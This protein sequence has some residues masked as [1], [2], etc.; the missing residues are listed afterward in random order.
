MSAQ[1]ASLWQK[2]IS[3]KIMLFV[4]LEREIGNKDIVKVIE[5]VQGIVPKAT[6]GKPI[7]SLTQGIPSTLMS[8][9]GGNSIRLTNF[10]YSDKVRGALFMEFND[11]Q[12]INNNLS[13]LEKQAEVMEIPVYMREIDINL[14]LNGQLR[15][16]DTPINSLKTI[17][18]PRYYSVIISGECPRSGNIREK[19]WREIQVGINPEEA[20]QI[21]INGVLR[22]VQI[23][24]EIEQFL[25]D[26]ETIYEKL[27]EHT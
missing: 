17:N 12:Q 13:I 20:S 24:G 11:R 10:V 3:S 21:I 1:T 6:P 26:I 15:C 16:L 9:P 22:D 7:L 8:A 2:V 23:K 14:V 4:L 18:S 19:P 5:S 27:I 25:R